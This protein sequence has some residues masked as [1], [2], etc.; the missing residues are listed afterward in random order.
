MAARASRRARIGLNRESENGYI[1]KNDQWM[2]LADGTITAYDL[3]IPNPRVYPGPRPYLLRIP[4]SGRDGTFSG[5]VDEGIKWARDYGI[6]YM[7]I[8][9]R[10]Q[11]RWRTRYRKSGNFL[12]ASSET[13]GDIAAAINLLKDLRYC[14]GNVGVYGNSLGG[15]GAALAAAWSGNPYPEYLYANN[16]FRRGETFP[17]VA[18]SV[19]INTPLD[20]LAG[21]IWNSNQWNTRW[22]RSVF[23]PQPIDW[24]TSSRGTATGIKWDENRVGQIQ[25]WMRADNV[26]AFMSHIGDAT[27]SLGG[28]NANMTTYLAAT[29]VPCLI[30]LSPDDAWR[31]WQSTASTV[32]S[33]GS[34]TVVNISPGGHDNPYQQTETNIQS[35]QY[36]AFVEFHLTGAN[37]NTSLAVFGGTDWDDKLE[38]RMVQMPT[39]AAD[40][41]SDSYVYTA[42]TIGDKSNFAGFT[43]T[44]IYVQNGGSLATTAETDPTGSTDITQNWND[45]TFDGDD[46]ITMLQDWADGGQDPVQVLFGGGTPKLVPGEAGVNLNTLGSDQVVAGQGTAKIFVEADKSEFVVAVSVWDFGGGSDEVYVTHGWKKIT[47][48]TSG[49]EEVDITLDPCCYELVNTRQL[50]VKISTY[51]VE[52]FFRS[53]GDT[54]NYVYSRPIFGTDGEVTLTIHHNATQTTRVELPLFAD[55]VTQLDA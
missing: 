11:G 38:C 35:Q 41:R 14:D 37:A 6:G 4:G 51:P 3:Y 13:L 40:R 45:T 42:K 23:R 7:A 49:I 16:W 46:W 12:A 44:A 29:T 24:Q 2:R 18:C 17:T 10:G 36:N 43:K 53:A 30:R 47:G 1:V 50:R 9:M 26:A 52:S 22:E 21:V 20:P 33:M 39:S 8:D 34:N 5:H 48:Y 27:T 54:Q 19:I 31:G 28:I 32:M 55:N 15:M 25:A